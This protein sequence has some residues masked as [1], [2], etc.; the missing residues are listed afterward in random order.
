MQ[1]GMTRLG[2]AGGGGNES[3]AGKS[4]EDRKGGGTASRRLTKSQ[5]PSVVIAPTPKIRDAL[6]TDGATVAGSLEEVVK[7]LKERTE[8]PRAIRLM[9]PAGRVSEH[10]VETLSTLLQGGG[11]IIDADDSFFEDGA[12]RAHLLEA[13]GMEDG[14]PA[15]GCF[16]NLVDTGVEHGLIRDYVESLD[17]GLGSLGSRSSLGDAEPRDL[18]QRFTLDLPELAE[19]WRRGS[20]IASW[21]FDLSATALVKDAGLGTRAGLVQDFVPVATEARWSL[22]A[23]AEAATPATQIIAALHAHLRARRRHA[24]TDQTPLARWFGVGGPLKSLERVEP[25]IAPGDRRP[26]TE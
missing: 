6:A 2:E 10:A 24:S 25:R 20:V 19:A 12:R 3:G 21:L 9:L 1:I 23:T 11:I 17:G 26:A 7:R 18:P 4:N 8:R 22:G 13:A 5:H 16:V 15:A 14:P